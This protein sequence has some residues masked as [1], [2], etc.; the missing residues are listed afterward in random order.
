[1][2]KKTASPWLTDFE[3][4]AGGVFFLLYLIVF[5][6]L[7]GWIFRGVELLLGISLSQSEENAL[8]YYVAFVLTILIFYN[9]IGKTTHRVFSGLG[10]T[11]AAAGVG[12]VAFYGLNELLYRLTS[13]ALGNQLN[14]NDITISAQIH[15]APRPTLLIVIFI[16][17]FVE[18]VLF[19]GYVFGMLRGHS[20]ILAWG[21]SCVLFAF[22]HVWQLAAGSW[23]LWTVVL[24]VQYLVPGLVLCWSYDRCGNLWAPILTHMAVNALYV[25]A[26]W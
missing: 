24:L 16:A 2:A 17:P 6:L 26:N 1:M 5:P 11:L 7:M 20:R 9:C 14:L 10:H 25:W 21:V 19:R 22:L 15:D 3:R 18:E 12:I 8:Y 4:I 23:S 13:V